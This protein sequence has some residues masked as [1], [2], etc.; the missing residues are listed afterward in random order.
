[1]SDPFG[2]LSLP[3]VPVLVLARCARCRTIV[4]KV[5][6][7]LRHAFWVPRQVPE[8]ELVDGGRDWFRS[9]KD[10][11]R[12]LRYGRLRDD[13]VDVSSMPTI[14][15][16]VGGTPRGWCPDDGVRCVDVAELE[17]LAR[18]AACDGQARDYRS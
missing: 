17:M 2:P 10:E 5:A 7:D 4:G 8:L 1:M 12:A 13:G 16:I 9:S 15:P 18:A 6:G 3:H 11:K 14:L